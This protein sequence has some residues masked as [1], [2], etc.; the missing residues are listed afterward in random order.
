MGVSV[1]VNLAG[2]RGR[3]PLPAAMMAGVVDSQEADPTAMLLYRHN[4]LSTDNLQNTRVNWLKVAYNIMGQELALTSQIG[5]VESHA[6]LDKSFVLD[7][8]RDG[9]CEPRLIRF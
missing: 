2:G 8:K 9:S 1:N 6:I 3:N 5:L 4:L 7:D